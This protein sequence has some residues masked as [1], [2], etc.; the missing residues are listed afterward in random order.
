MTE[1]VIRNQIGGPRLWCR[2]HVALDFFLRQCLR[3][4]LDLIQLPAHG[5]FYLTTI[6]HSAKQQGPLTFALETHIS[7]TQ[8]VITIDI[9]VITTTPR[10]IITQRQM[11]PTTT[12]HRGVGISI[13]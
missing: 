8:I 9:N 6:I 5:F 1:I 10:R 12:L 11:S 3:P 2:Q 13:R 4:H 7:V